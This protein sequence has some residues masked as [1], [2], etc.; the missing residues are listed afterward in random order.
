MRLLLL[1]LLLGADH[2]AMVCAQTIF[3]LCSVSD[4]NLLGI[5][6]IINQ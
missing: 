5:K 3:C 2:L 4:F 1:L 6:K